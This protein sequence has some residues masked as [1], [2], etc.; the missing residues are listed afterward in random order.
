MCN[1]VGNE[2]FLYKLPWVNAQK[3]STA[4]RYA[5]SPPRSSP[6]NK[7][8]PPAGYAKAY[9]N[10]IFLKIK[11]SGHMVPLDQPEVAF[12]MMNALI[13]NPKAFTDSAEQTKLNMQVPGDIGLCEACPQC[14]KKQECPI[15]PRQQEC[16]S[17]PTPTNTVPNNN[18]TVIASSKTQMEVHTPIASSKTQMEV[19]TP[20]QNKKQYSIQNVVNGAGIGAFIAFALIMVLIIWLKY[21]RTYRETVPSTSDVEFTTV[22]EYRD[23]P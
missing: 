6:N 21:R 23:N 10:L 5:W 20:S 3:F 17:C 15:C 22:S 12:Q 13:N 9:E 7:E 11:E 2:R 8:L 19:Q 14:P 16:P 1:H 18:N 4:K